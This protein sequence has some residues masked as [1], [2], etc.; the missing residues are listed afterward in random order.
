MNIYNPHKIEIVD[1]FIRLFQI[2]LNEKFP[3]SNTD[4]TLLPLPDGE[5][6][7]DDIVVRLGN[8]IFLSEKQIGLLGLTQPEIYAAIAHELGHI[9]YHTNPWVADSESRAD[10]L[11][12]ELGLRDQMIAVIEKII[13]SRRYRHITS[14]L[15]QRINFL[16]LLA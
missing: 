16:G 9:L 15:V 10:T 6:E 2:P 13:L 1:S 12:A 4:I 14:L 8:K 7:Y 5:N 11:A 3:E